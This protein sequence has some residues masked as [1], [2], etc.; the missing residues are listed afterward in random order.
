MNP[1]S[2]DRL[3]GVVRETSFSIHR[4]LRPAHVEKVYENALLRRLRKAGLVVE[5]R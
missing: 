2:I 4:N 3:C 1:E 5:A